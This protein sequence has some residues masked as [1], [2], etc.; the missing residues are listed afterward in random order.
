M[1]EAHVKPN[2]VVFTEYD[3]L[4]DERQDTKG[5]RQTNSIHLP[6]G[7]LPRTANFKKLE[8]EILQQIIANIGRHDVERKCVTAENLTLD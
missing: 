8:A 3:G 4:F 7:N 5:K 2:T 1:L 6:S